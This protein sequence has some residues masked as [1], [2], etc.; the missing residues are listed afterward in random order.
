MI[1][2]LLTPIFTR[3][4]GSYLRELEDILANGPTP[5]CIGRTGNQ[6]LT[7]LG[8]TAN[9]FAQPHLDKKDMGFAFLSWFVK[10]KR[11]LF[12][13]YSYIIFLVRIYILLIFFVWFFTEREGVGHIKMGGEF[14]LPEYGIFILPRNGTTMAFFTS[15]VLHCTNVAHGYDNIGMSYSAK[16][17]V[18]KKATRRTEEILSFF[19]DCKY[20]LIFHYI[21]ISIIF[22]I[23]VVFNGYLFTCILILILFLTYFVLKC[24]CCR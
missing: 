24:L 9:Y 18:Q 20:Y 17:N 6:G 14:L 4:F 3:Q 2:V 12:F 21:S 13:C 8:I 1:N 19:K 16:H 11:L 22:T 5:L 15:K 10:G 7:T 23:F